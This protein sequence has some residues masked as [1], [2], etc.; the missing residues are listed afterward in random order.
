MDQGTLHRDTSIFDRSCSGLSGPP[1]H[2]GAAVHCVMH[3]EVCKT[4]WSRLAW[5]WGWPS[6]L[7]RPKQNPSPKR[8]EPNAA[9]AMD[10]KR[11][12]G[13]EPRVVSMSLSLDAGH[14]VCEAKEASQPGCSEGCGPHCSPKTATEFVRQL[15]R[16]ADALSHGHFRTLR[17]FVV[18]GRWGGGATRVQSGFAYTACPDSLECSSGELT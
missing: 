12:R 3:S 7:G 5:R 8:W 14:L 13:T 10:L 9:R 2:C 4:S 18:A 11:I 17:H 15:G 16:F 6:R 1:H